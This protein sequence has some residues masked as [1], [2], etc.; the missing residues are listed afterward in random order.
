MKFDKV[1]KLL[2]R[3]DIIVIHQIS[4]SYP[5]PCCLWKKPVKFLSNVSILIKNVIVLILILETDYWDESQKK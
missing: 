1:M 2:L 4:H 5:C 3:E